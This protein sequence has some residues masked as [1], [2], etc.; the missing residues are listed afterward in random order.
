MTLESS[1]RRDFLALAFISK[2]ISKKLLI[3]WIINWTNQ[4]AVDNF[5]FNSEKYGIIRYKRL[6]RP[7]TKW[8]S[9]RPPLMA[10]NMTTTK[11]I[12]HFDFTAPQK[13]A[14]RKIS[15]S[16]E[17][18]LHDKTRGKEIKLSL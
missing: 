8:G 12:R 6:S 17:N 7:V 10:I 18:R 14:G 11:L 4:F 9:Q 2:S 1:K 5:G 15:D 16:R 13:F 3:K